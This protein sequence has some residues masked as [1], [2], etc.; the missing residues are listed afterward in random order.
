MGS[1]ALQVDSLPTELSGKPRYSKNLFENHLGSLVTSLEKP[2]ENHLFP[3]IFWNLRHP[4]CF[5]LPGNRRKSA[6]K[7]QLE[8]WRLRFHR[9]MLVHPTRK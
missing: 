9:V 6:K 3:N 1:L 8:L 4:C 2:L 5:Q 7:F